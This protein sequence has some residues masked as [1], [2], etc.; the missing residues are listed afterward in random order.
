MIWLLFVLIQIINLPLMI[1]C[2]P[3][4]GFDLIFNDPAIPRFQP[5]REG[6]TNRSFYDGSHC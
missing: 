1:I 3:V 2:I 4:I 6:A 5:V